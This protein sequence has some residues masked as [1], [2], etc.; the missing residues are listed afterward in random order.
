VL[1]ACG[2]GHPG[3]NPIDYQGWYGTAEAVR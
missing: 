1:G 3:L 2:I